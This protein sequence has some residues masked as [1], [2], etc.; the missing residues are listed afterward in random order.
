MH[1][2]IIIGTVR[3][4]WSKLWANTMFHKRISSFA[5]KISIFESRWR[6]TAAAYNF[7]KELLFTIDPIPLP[8]KVLCQCSQA[9]GVPA[10][11]LFRYIGLIC[12]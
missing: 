1:P 2:A 10:Y 9:C 12:A 5:R 6:K 3:S 7:V 8:H 11:R 4:L